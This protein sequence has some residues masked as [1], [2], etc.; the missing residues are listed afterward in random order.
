MP[1]YVSGSGRL[2]AEKDPDAILDYTLDLTDWLAGDSLDSLTVTVQNLTLIR[3]EIVGDKA[4]AWVSGGTVG[5]QGEVQ[6]RF[7]TIAG[8]QDDRTLYVKIKEK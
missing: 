7:A 3:S 2:K 4:V 5:T 8:R 6:F 1:I